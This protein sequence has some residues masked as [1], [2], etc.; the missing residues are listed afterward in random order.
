MKRSLAI[1]TAIVVPIWIVM[2]LCTH[3]EPVQRDGW[4]HFLYHRHIGLSFGSLYDFAKG[5]YTHNNPRLGQVFTL[6]QFTPGPWH[7]IVTPIVE[8]AL[9]YLLAAVVLGRW[10]SVRSSDDAVL[11]MVI[12]AL[13]A[14]ASPQFGLILFY[15]PYTGNYLFGLAVNLAFLVPYRFHFEARRADRWWWIPIMI[16][17]GFASGMANEHTGPAIVAA[18]MLATF[19]VWRRDR[20]VPVWAIAGIVAMIAGGIALFEAPGQAIRYNGLANHGSLIGRV[21]ARGIV[22]DLGL[23]G[24]LAGYLA[25]TLP[26]IVIAVAARFA[27]GPTPA[28]Q[29]RRRTELALVGIAVAIVATLLVS[30]KVGPRLYFGAVALGCAGIAGFVVRHLVPRWSKLAVAAL[31]AGW[32]LFAGYKCVSAYHEVGPEFTTRLALLEHAPAN[33]V[34]DLPS[35]TVHRSRWVLDDDLAISQIRNMVAF[36]FQLALIRLDGVGVADVPVSDDP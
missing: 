16:V 30:P 7:E 34:L 31:S 10:P 28:T 22:A 23:F 9:F 6:L 26:W 13:T 12:V 18:A 24:S 2:V 35:Y 4:G 33:S 11:F 29:P 15:R 21:L 20:K 14:L 19:E 17:L 5:T 1:W 3:W 27:V 32:L 8:L 36:S 25:L